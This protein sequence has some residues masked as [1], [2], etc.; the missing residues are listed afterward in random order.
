MEE[1]E[2]VIRIFPQ[3]LRRLLKQA[4]TD[5]FQAEEMRLRAGRPFLMAAEGK[6]WFLLSDGSNGC[7][8][9]GGEGRRFTGRLI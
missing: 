1:M 6:D 4:E 5:R 9:R 8:R 2:Q 7:L 3:K